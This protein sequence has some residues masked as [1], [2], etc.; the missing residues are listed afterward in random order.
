MTR[1]N[2]AEDVPAELC[3]DVP[4]LRLLV[5]AICNE[6]DAQLGYWWIEPRDTA[7]VTLRLELVQPDL[8]RI[9]AARER[10]S[11]DNER[12]PVRRR[13]KRASWR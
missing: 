9:M 3:R 1:L 10:C 5:D 13:S 12:L 8:G 4:S 2:L 7:V 11:F 6:R